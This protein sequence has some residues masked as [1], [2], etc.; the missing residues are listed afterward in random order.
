MT[1]F[2]RRAQYNVQRDYVSAVM[3]L[4]REVPLIAPRPGDKFLAGAA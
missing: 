3:I 2:H 4:A 1:A